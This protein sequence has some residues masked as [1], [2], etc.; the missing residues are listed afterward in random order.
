MATIE[1]AL[2]VAPIVLAV[3]PHFA[4]LFGLPA[5]LSKISAVQAIFDVVAGNY[6][7]AINLHK[8]P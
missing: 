3:L 6:G 8:K 5:W 1:T 2:T 7:K 4:A